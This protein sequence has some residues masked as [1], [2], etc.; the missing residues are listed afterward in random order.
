MNPKNNPV[1]QFQK[2]PYVFGSKSNTLKFLQKKIKKSKIEP[3]YDFTVDEWNKNQ[4][5]ILKNISRQFNSK[6]IIRSSALGEDS[7][8]SSQAGNFQSILNINS[9]SKISV[10]KAIKSVIKSYEIGNNTN[11]NNQILIQ[12]QSKNIFVSG[13]VF[14]R[15]PEIASPYY[16]INYD[17]SDSTVGVTSGIVGNTIK[18]FRNT[19]KNSISKQW[20]NLLKSI[21]EIESILNLDKLDIEFGINKDTQVIIFQV[22]PITFIQKINVNQNDK[23]IQNLILQNKKKFCKLNETNKLYGKKTFFSDMSDWN[24]A[25]IIGNNPNLF[26]YSLYDF[27]IMKNSWSK[28]IMN[29]GY[30]NM[31]STPLMVR[32][33]S[34]PYV[35]IRTSFNSFLPSKLPSTIKKK[36]LSFY[37]DKLKKSPFLHDKVEFEILF[38]CYD[39]TLD[40][41]LNELKKAKFSSK[42]IHIIKSTLIEFTNE[43]IQNFNTILKNSN[44]SIEILTNKRNL[45]LSNLKPKN[46]H[47]ALLITAEKLLNDCKIYGAIPFSTMAR[48]AFISTI[49]LKSLQKKGHVT[50]E[51]VDVFLNS[52]ST[53]LSEIQNDLYSYTSGKISKNQFLKKYGHLR[54]GTYDITANRYDKQQEFLNNMKIFIT[55]KKSK[56]YSRQKKLVNL[57]EKHN[58][59]FNSIDFFDF[60]EQSLVS[61]EK[62]KFEFTKNLSAAIELIAEAGQKLGFSREEMSNLTITEILKAKNHTNSETKQIWK[63][64]ISKEL[65]NKLIMDM[66]VLPP[67]IFSE[68]DFE[69]I[70]Y[71]ISK[72][73]FITNKKITSSLCNLEK[74]Q[75]KIDEIENNIILIEHADP[76]FDWIFTKNPAALITKYGGVA[77]H[78]AIRCAEIGL[79]AAIGCGEILYE[80]LQSSSTVMLDCKNSEILILENSDKDEEIEARKVLKSLGYIK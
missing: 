16:V 10:K 11:K 47:N 68:K 62:L 37:L 67:L 53:S 1:H 71:F 46:S 33:G 75:Q 24:P 34:K 29:I 17:E 55:K 31:K 49:I 76:G 74:Y 19:K 25:E 57:F 12:N 44:N 70:D 64:L 9:S 45:I 22:R 65:S 51:S 27:L 38:S 69:I 72:P 7:L 21:K 18:I 20:Q 28:G 8:E 30:E 63:K 66:Q 2:S 50:N 32:F 78:M 36:L 73:N 43:I 58:L 80:K 13:V 41:R 14:T 77:S 39:L 6:I 61:R 35:D 60:V 3:I 40:S 5:V 56:K 52:I 4:K 79:P 42:E 59:Q 23:K 54:P 48:I 15:T 26:D